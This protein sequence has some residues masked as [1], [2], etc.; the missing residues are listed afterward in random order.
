M[1]GASTRQWT[2]WDSVTGKR[3]CY[4]ADPDTVGRDIAVQ[5]CSALNVMEV[6]EDQVQQEN[7]K[8]T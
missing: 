8:R 4:V 1:R 7:K 2:V 6:I 5:I 3:L